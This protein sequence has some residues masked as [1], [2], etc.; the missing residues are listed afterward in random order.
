[1]LSD[2]IRFCYCVY[3]QLCIAGYHGVMGGFLGAW[4]W[5]ARKRGEGQEVEI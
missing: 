1:M 3:H 2:F 4:E 5:K